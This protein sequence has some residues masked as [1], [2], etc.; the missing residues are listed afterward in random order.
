M[1]QQ[2]NK[3]FNMKDLKEGT[4][5]IFQPLSGEGKERFSLWDNAAKKFIKEGEKIKTSQ[6]E[7]DVN[8]FIALKK[9]TTDEQSRWAR[10]VVFT[11]EVIINNEK[12]NIDMPLSAERVLKEKM[13]DITAMAQDPLSFSFILSKSKGSNGMTQYSLRLGPKVSSSVA[14]Q[15]KTPL[16]TEEK[17]LVEVMK[18]DVN[19]MNRSKEEKIKLL[20]KNL[21]V[22]ESRAQEIVNA[23]F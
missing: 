23:H 14:N 18:S 13:T 20:V 4:D 21:Q 3:W 15:F 5:L 17:D 22:H 10:K 16:T 7:L 9:L 1:E 19:T 6:G 8:K 11:R 2:K 12:M